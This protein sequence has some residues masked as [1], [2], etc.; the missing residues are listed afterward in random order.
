[1]NPA[2][3]WDDP[4]R[5]K[6][7]ELVRRLRAKLRGRAERAL[8]FGSHAAGR[9]TALSDVDLIVVRETALPWP[10]RGEPFAD[11]WQAFGAIDLLVYTPEE[12]RALLSR[13][14]PFLR[15]ARKSW[16]EILPG[17]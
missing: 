6:R 8:L 17:P 16:V 10:E 5:W 2:V 11:M 14:T 3:I 1:M 9:A 15:E 12:W 7:S 4:P 13:P